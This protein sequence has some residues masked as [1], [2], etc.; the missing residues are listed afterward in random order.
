[1]HG[2]RKINCQPVILCDDKLRLA[3]YRLLVRHIPT[4][5]VLAESEIEAGIKLEIIDKL[6]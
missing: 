6:G 3:L 1:M 5:T 2:H 4:I